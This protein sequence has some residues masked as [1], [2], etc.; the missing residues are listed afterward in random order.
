MRVRTC[1]QGAARVAAGDGGPCESHTEQSRAR[2]CAAGVALENRVTHTALAVAPCVSGEGGREGGHGVVQLHDGEDEALTQP[3]AG[4]PDGTPRASG[5]AL[6]PLWR[7]VP[8]GREFQSL[9]SWR[10]FLGDRVTSPEGRR[11]GRHTLS[12]PPPQGGTL[13]HAPRGAR[14]SRVAW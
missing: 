6:E 2:E 3:A 7:R 11:C 4:N 9:G 10:S 14:R 1:S 5:R 13:A 8:F 12:P